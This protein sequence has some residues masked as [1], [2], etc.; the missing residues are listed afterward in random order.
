MCSTAESVI[1]EIIW[2]VCSGR[3]RTDP[4]S[5]RMRASASSC[6]R[7]DPVGSI[8]RGHNGIA[9][10]PQEAG[11]AIEPRCQAEA[12]GGSRVMQRHPSST[13]SP[14]PLGDGPHEE[15]TAFREFVQRVA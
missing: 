13:A 7:S 2:E 4:L 5:S 8:R 1:W 11:A 3:T 15:I 10:S 12:T 6:V 14:L 9:G